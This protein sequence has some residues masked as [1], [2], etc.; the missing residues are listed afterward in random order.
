MTKFKVLSD[1]EIA[2]VLRNTSG[3]KLKFESKLTNQDM[4]AFKDEMRLE[5]SA[6]K[7]AQLEKVV[8]MLEGIDI[9]RS[10]AAW[11]LDFLWSNDSEPRLVPDEAVPLMVKFADKMINEAIQTIKQSLQQAIKEERQDENA[12]PKPND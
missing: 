10:N 11:T 7:Q 2:E 5:L 1:D 12:I 4:A 6:T 3:T 8:E 9:F